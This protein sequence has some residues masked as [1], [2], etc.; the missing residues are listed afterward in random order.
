MTPVEYREFIEERILD[1]L[2][3]LRSKNEITP[4]RTKAVAATVL[5]SIREDMSVDDLYVAVQKLKYTC[6]ELALVI[7]LAMDKYDDMKKVEE[8]QKL[9]KS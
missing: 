7:S 8:A 9:K 1:I 3:D 4:E 6:P 5:D 2:E